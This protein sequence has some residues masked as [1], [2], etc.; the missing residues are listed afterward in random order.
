MD[1]IAKETRLISD[2]CNEQDI[3]AFAISVPCHPKNSVKTTILFFLLQPVAFVTFENREQAEEAKAALQVK[4]EKVPFY[5][6]AIY[7][8]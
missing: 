5:A 7:I 1:I 3:F 4:A 8:A 2:N 6:E